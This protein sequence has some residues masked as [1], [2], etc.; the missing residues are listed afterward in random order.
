MIQIKTYVINL[1]RSIERRSYMENQLIR[2]PFLQ[3]EFISA[4]DGRALSED[5]RSNKFDEEKFKYIYRRAVRPGEIGCTLSHQKC[6]RYL[7]DNNDN[8]ALILEDDTILKDNIERILEEIVNLLECDQSPRIILLSGWYYYTKKKKLIDRYFLADIYDGYG[9]YA[10]VVNRKAA[11]LLLED[12][13]FITADDWAY[14]KRK[15]VKIQAV[16]PHL[17]IT[18]EDCNNNLVSTISNETKLVSRKISLKQMAIYLHSL[19]LK[20]FK[21][22]GHFEKR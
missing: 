12:K 5:E 6:Y 8:Y 7:E 9:T 3:Y 18:D 20:L 10:Y 4:V 13:P 14:I 21:L 17:L 16:Y 22:T 19:I 11:E 1:E 2:F 15:G